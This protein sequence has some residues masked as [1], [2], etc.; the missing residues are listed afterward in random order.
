MARAPGALIS[1][2]CSQRMAAQVS[3]DILFDDLRNNCSDNGVGSH[4]PDEVLDCGTFH[5]RDVGRFTSLR[6]TKK[7]D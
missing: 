1:A 2:A 6:R 5:G 7:R 3:V 4:G